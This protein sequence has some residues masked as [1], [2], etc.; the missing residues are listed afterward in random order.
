MPAVY[1]EV[2]KVQRLDRVRHN[3]EKGGLKV[4]FV[5]FYFV[6]VNRRLRDP[7]AKIPRY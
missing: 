4:C 1:E 5:L 2:E 3:N 7:P 6:V